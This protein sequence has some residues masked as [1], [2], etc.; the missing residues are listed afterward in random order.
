MDLSCAFIQAW[1][2]SRPGHQVPMGLELAHVDADLAEKGGYADLA[3]TRDR[4][5][6]FDD[7]SKG[8]HRSF[9]VPVELCNGCL[10]R[11]DQVQV[12]AQQSALLEG[13]TPVQC[14]HQSFTLHP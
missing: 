13:Q 11:L 14:L 4:L 5:Q 6:S 7:P 10:Y 9:D 3:E 1:T 8:G 2:E 12:H